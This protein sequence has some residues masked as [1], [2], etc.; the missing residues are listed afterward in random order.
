MARIVKSEEL[1]WVGRVE[2]GDN[3]VET[4]NTCRMLLW[5]SHMNCCTDE[6]E[7]NGTYIEMEIVESS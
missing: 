7:Q 3:A 1:G 6:R 5:E 2:A 4:R